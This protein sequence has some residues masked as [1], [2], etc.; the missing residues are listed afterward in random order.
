MHAEK[1]FFTGRISSGAAGSGLHHTSALI[2]TPADY[3]PEKLNI[4]PGATASPLVPDA[5]R[6]LNQVPTHTEQTLP[7]KEP[8]PFINTLEVRKNFFSFAIPGCDMREIF[9]SIAQDPA[10]G[11]DQQVPKLTSLSDT[12]IHNFIRNYTAGN[13]ENSF[14]KEVYGCQGVAMPPDW[15]F[16]EIRATITPRNV[17]PANMKFP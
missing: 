8:D 16:A 12:E 11:I 7:V 14:M 13:N 9:P 3:T 2:F 10:Y 4:T 6:T 15:N 5:T 17:K 1:N